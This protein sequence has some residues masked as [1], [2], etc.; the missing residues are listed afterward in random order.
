MHK[1]DVGVFPDCFFDHRVCTITPSCP[2]SYGELR[3]YMETRRSK[4]PLIV[5]PGAGAQGKGIFLT[6]SLSDISAYESFVVQEY[7]PKVFHYA[8]LSRLASCCRFVLSPTPLHVFY[9]QRVLCPSFLLFI[10]VRV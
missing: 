4:K 2:H 9:R 6:R 8:A 10:L 3:R 5:K 7:L 1:C